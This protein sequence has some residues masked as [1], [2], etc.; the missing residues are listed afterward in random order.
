MSEGDLSGACDRF[1]DGM[2]ATGG[3]W[4][5]ETASDRAGAHSGHP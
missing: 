3:L 5:R 4:P 1:A 2:T